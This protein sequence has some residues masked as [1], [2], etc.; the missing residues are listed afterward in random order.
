MKLTPQQLFNLLE[1]ASFY[2]STDIKANCPWCGQK[3]FYIS[4]NENHL[5]NCVRKKKCG[6]TGNIYKLL[7]KL[8]RY[9]LYSTLKEDIKWSQDVSN[10]LEIIQNDQIDIE[11]T[12]I[13]FPIGFRRIYFDKYLESRNFTNVDFNKYLIGETKLVKKLI[14]YIIIIIFQDFKP[15]AYISRFKGSKKEIEKIEASSNKKVIRYSNSESDFAKIIGNYDDIVKGVTKTIILVE[16]FFDA[17]NIIDLL[18][19]ENDEELKCCFTFKCAVSDE[20]IIRLQNKEVEN[21][22]LL[23]DP[24][25]IDKIKEQALHLSKFFNVKIGLIEATNNE[26]ELKDPGELVIDELVEVFENLY[27]P[28]DFYLKKVSIIELK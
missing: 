1:N 16:G 18:D 7:Q 12:E 27:L 26:G 11:L 9:D 23:Y 3:E 5:F 14:N 22:I 17:K 6:E 28:L 19:L 8:K 15:V 25:V 21:I 10:S 13:K 4:L 20:Q 24:D 2:K